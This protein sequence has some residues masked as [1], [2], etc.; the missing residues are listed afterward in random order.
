[1]D[2]FFFIAALAMGYL[3]YQTQ[4][5]RMEFQDNEIRFTIKSS[6]TNIAFCYGTIG[7]LILITLVTFYQVVIV[8]QSDF[9]SI[10]KLL[11]FIILGGG[12]VFNF[13]TRYFVTDSGVFVAGVLPTVIRG[14]SWAKIEKVS[15]N[16][17]GKVVFSVQYKKGIMEMKGQSPEDEEGFIAFLKTRCQ[18]ERV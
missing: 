17:K 1:M 18:V 11:F 2:N 4:K 7:M 6:K 15:I 9:D 3:Y 12:Q 14:Q 8:A 13:P 16:M 10:S 5:K